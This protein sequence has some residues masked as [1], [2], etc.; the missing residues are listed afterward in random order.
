[1]AKKILTGG[2]QTQY[3]QNNVKQ[4]QCRYTPNTPY[5]YKAGNDIKISDIISDDEKITIN[6]QSA[7]DGGTQV[8]ASQMPLQTLAHIQGLKSA[9]MVFMKTQ[10]TVTAGTNQVDYIEF[11]IPVFF[12][13]RKFAS[14]DV[15]EV[16]VTLEDGTIEIWS[17]DTPFVSPAAPAV[18]YRQKTVLPGDTAEIPK[19]QMLYLP[20]KADF[21]LQIQG[22]SI[23][24]YDYIDF[25]SLFADD[26]V[27]NKT[28]YQLADTL[29]LDVTQLRTVQLVNTSESNLR[30][31]FIENQA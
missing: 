26:W 11:V 25:Q 16:S 9:N 10:A 24:Q 13:C 15:L 12:Q 31:Y 3:S 20:N 18:L 27:S 21:N 6:F 14:G 23:S 29:G 7:L 8:I 4:L 30:Y 19:M 2:T 17:V 1:M 5:Q 22:N 28:P